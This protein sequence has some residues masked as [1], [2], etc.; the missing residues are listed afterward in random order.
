MEKSLSLLTFVLVTYFIDVTEAKGFI[1]LTG[2]GVWG[3]V[4]TVISI[5]CCISCC[6]IKF[7]NL[8]IRL[9]QLC[10]SDEKPKSTGQNRPI[11]QGQVVCTE[12]GKKFIWTGRQWAPFEENETSGNQYATV[13][14]T[15]Y[16][17]P[18]SYENATEGDDREFKT[19]HI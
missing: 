19:V 16:V 11:Q 5:L 9:V 18:P 7:N 10:N 2:F 13:D 17:P 8:I 12:D 15:S 1:I 6:L 4:I 14:L 3:T